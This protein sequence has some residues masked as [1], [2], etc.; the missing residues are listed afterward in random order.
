MADKDTREAVLDLAQQFVQTRGYNGFSYRDLAERI[1]IRAPSIHYYFPSKTDLGLAMVARYQD[2]FLSH[3]SRIEREE[4]NDPRR[5]LQRYVDVYRDLMAT[6]DHLCLGAALAG[7]Q[8]SLPEGIAQA[9]RAL[10]SE[11]VAWLEKILDAGRAQ[12]QFAFQGSAAI[13]AEALFSS[14]EGVM[15]VARAFNDVQRYETATRWLL[16]GLRPEPAAI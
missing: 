14:I 13:A 2:R 12:G 7:E 8:E 1:G 6:G 16:A 4:K 9:V 11:N 5:C 3:L 15:L 10:F